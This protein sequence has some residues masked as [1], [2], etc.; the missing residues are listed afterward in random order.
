MAEELVPEQLV[1][2][3]IERQTEL[4]GIV[5]HIITSTS[6]APEIEDMDSLDI[7]NI[8]LY[9]PRGSK[10]GTLT[11]NNTFRP[12]MIHRF[13]TLGEVRAGVEAFIA[14]MEQEQRE[15][16]ELARKMAEARTFAREQARKQRE[17]SEEEESKKEAPETKASDAPSG[18]GS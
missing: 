15:R 7:G 17:Q 18:K 2:Q 6:P 9:I 13:T 5:Y 3:A 10:L 11:S 12:L 14:R 8:R 16:E 1:L 4:H